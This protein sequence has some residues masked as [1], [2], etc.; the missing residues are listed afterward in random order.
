MIL[1]PLP[2][3]LYYASF[4]STVFLI[5]L[6]L[7][8]SDSQ[9][10]FKKGLSCNHAI[11]AV[12]RTIESSLRNGN[13]VNLC[14]ID[15]SKAF[16]KVNLHALFIKLMNRKVSVQVLQLLKNMIFTW[17]T[18]VKWAEFFLQSHMVFARAPF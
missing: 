8:S 10:G 12:L 14:A 15:L 13:T 18:C 17:Y 4:L 6:V 7:K 3:S 5:D 9:F 16:D 11:Y 2:L 1:G